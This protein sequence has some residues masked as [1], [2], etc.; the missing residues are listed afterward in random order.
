M[1]DPK[2]PPAKD[3]AD[4]RRDLGSPYGPHPDGVD[5]AAGGADSSP[6]ENVP[7]GERKQTAEEKK[8]KG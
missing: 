8:A 2:T 4:D 3:D 1:A 6:L 5:Q 7:T